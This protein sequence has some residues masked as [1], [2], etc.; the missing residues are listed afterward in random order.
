MEEQAEYQVA[1]SDIG[2]EVSV[3]QYVTHEGLALTLT[4]TQITIDQSDVLLDSLYQFRQ[5]SMFYIG[6]LLNYWKNK[7]EG[8]Y[9]QLLDATKYEMSTLDSAMWVCKNI[10]PNGRYGPPLTFGHHDAVASLDPESQE[11][12]LERAIEGGWSVYRLRQEIKGPKKEKPTKI[13]HVPCPHCGAEFDIE[14]QQLKDL[15]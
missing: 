11:L 3:A 7:D 13:F 15:C 4:G 2:N 14:E 9:S 1:K 12:W 10:R 8:M 5:R 6:D